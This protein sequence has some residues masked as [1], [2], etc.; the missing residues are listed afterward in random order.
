MRVSYRWFNWSSFRHVYLIPT[1]MVAHHKSQFTG[2][3]KF[4]ALH[5]YWLKYCGFL[6]FERNRI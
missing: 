4:I 5:F 3:V 6:E 2:R 1:I